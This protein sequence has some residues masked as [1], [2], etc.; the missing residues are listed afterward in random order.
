MGLGDSSCVPERVRFTVCEI[1]FRDQGANLGR[2]ICDLVRHAGGE[3]VTRVAV[4]R[5]VFGS[6]PTAVSGMTTNPVNRI[7]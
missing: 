2:R 7:T 5:K 4:H 6:N 1:D 3:A